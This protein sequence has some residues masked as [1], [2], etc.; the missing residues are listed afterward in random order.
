MIS[1]QLT[2]SQAEALQVALNTA[3]AA[4]EKTDYAGFKPYIQALTQV[5][6]KLKK[7]LPDFSPETVREI[8]KREVN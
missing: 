6:I 4:L 3:I 2:K 7:L 5:E 8:L 1:L